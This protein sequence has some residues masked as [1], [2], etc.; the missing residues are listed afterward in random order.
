MLKRLFR[1]FKRVHKHDYTIEFVHH[2]SKHNSMSADPCTAKIYRCKCGYEYR[3][4]TPAGEQQLD[5]GDDMQELLGYK[6]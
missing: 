1:S 4:L 2:T 3:I 6:I 5:W